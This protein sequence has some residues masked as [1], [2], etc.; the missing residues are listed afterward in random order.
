M[1]L[2]KQYES[3]EERITAILLKQWLFDSHLWQHVEGL[4]MKKCKWC[5]AEST[6]EMKVT[7]GQE[8]CP[9]NPII[10]QIFKN[11]KNILKKKKI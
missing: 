4:K 5:L 2:L 11:A 1:I 10:L 9:Q 8:F 6:V 3:A 7:K